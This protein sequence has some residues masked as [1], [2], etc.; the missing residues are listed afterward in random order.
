MITLPVVMIIAM[1]RIICGND[2][3]KRSLMA[4]RIII[5]VSGRCKKK[6]YLQIDEVRGAT[7]LA[8]KLFEAHFGTV[9][10]LDVV[11]G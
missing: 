6:L 2:L 10:F 4:R 11:V 5:Y 7:K 1:M 8:L 9:M 3:M